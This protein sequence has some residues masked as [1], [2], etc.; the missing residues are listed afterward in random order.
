MT[1]TALQ[2]PP[3]VDAPEGNVSVPTV[4]MVDDEPSV[5][6]AL[7][8][9]F[10][11]QGIQTLQATSGAEGLVLLASNR[12]DLVVSDMRMPEMDGA[13]FLERVKEHDRSIVR[14]LLTGYADMSSTVAAI[15]KGA[16]H[17][18]IAKPWDDNELVLAVREALVRRG[19]EQ[20]N[21]ELTELTK[22]QN[23]Q[24]REANQTLESRV[25]AR[26]VELQQINGMLDA[27]YEDLNNT[28]V[29]AVNVFSS[30]LEMRGGQS[31]H[32]RRVAEI[33][34]ETAK[35]LGMS[36]REIRDVY[37][38]ALVHDIGTIGFPDAM[39][40]KA[41]SAFTADEHQRYRRHTIDG[42]T[43]LMAMTQLQAVARIVR[44]HHERPDGKGFP[45]GLSG[46][47]IVPGARIVA[48]ASG[49]DD[50]L[51]G[52]MG[53]QRYSMENAKRMLLGGIDTH[54][55]RTVIET[56]VQ[57]VDDMA[58]AAKADV[59]LDVRELRPGMVLARAMV[60]SKGT[61][62]LAAGHV[63]DERMVR[64]VQEF[65]RRESVRMSLWVQPA[66]VPSDDR[67]A[68]TQ[69]AQ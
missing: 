66:S 32:S 69:G 19:L 53:Q 51:Q 55:D 28:F 46:P 29:H 40:G 37:L 21:A 3:S 60:S 10:R 7:R 35:R 23:E 41:I 25:E 8:R 26:T 11:A 48:A 17:R 30:L 6:S 49:L 18:F 44:Q 54:Y 1:T 65:S 59:H 15:N 62:L 56:M 14:I 31:G 12:V 47:D 50:L 2:E 42:E 68:P 57:V 36:E 63:F 4:L 61:T 67:A 39:L 5:L 24:L 43:A 20:K 38:A 16:I 58:K 9:V 33:S 64:Q 45:D 22:R 34:R 52:N 13:R 27:A